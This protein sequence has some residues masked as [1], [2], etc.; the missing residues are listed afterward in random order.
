MKKFFITLLSAALILTGTLTA[1]ADEGTRPSISISSPSERLIKVNGEIT[2]T[3]TFADAHGEEV[4][5]NPSLVTE[6]FDYTERQII[7]VKPNCY[8]IIYSGVNTTGINRIKVLKGGGIVHELETIETPN[9]QSFFVY[10]STKREVV[11][12]YLLH[13]LGDNNADASQ[14]SV[15][16]DAPAKYNTLYYQSLMV[17]NGE[18]ELNLSKE[19]EDEE[20]YIINRRIALSK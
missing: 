15:F 16:T 7:K 18:G 14:D 3:I 12:D 19:L 17:G 5:L 4:A 11:A 20:A 6:T 9:S 10:N 8:D 13:I 2:Y 1:F